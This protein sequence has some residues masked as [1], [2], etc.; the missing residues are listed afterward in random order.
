MLPQKYLQAMIAYV[1]I[2]D[3]EHNVGFNIQQ[4]DREKF[5]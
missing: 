4:Q 1:N 3:V 5:G 2:T